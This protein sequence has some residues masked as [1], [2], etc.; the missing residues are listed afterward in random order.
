MCEVWFWRSWFWWLAGDFAGGQFARH[1][2]PRAQYGDER[3]R[4]FEMESRDSPRF[5]FHGLVLLQVE[6]VGSLVVVTVVVFV[7]VALVGR[8][9]WIVL[10]PHLSKCS[11][12][13]LLFW[14]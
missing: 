2:P 5:F 6:K 4:N 10:T 3:S 12:L 13:V 9:V 14:Y 1:F 7:E 11:A 8:M